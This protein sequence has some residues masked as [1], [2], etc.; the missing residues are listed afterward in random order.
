VRPFGGNALALHER[1]L[2]VLPCG[3]EDG[4]VPLV[5]GWQTGK[6]SA[7]TIAKWARQHCVPARLL[8]GPWPPPAI[9]AR[10]AGAQKGTAPGR[11]RQGN[12]NRRGRA[13]RRLVRPLAADRAARGKPQRSSEARSFNEQSLSPPLPDAEVAKTARSAWRYQSE[14]RNW[15][16][17]EG[18]V[19]WPVAQVLRCAP[20]KQGGDALILTTVLRAKH[21]TRKESFAAATRAMARDQVIPGWSEHRTRQGLQ[22]A[23]KLGL[24]TRIYKG[25]QGPG[26][27]SRY[28]L[29]KV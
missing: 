10:I 7:E 5:R 15:V 14:K 6:R 26:D 22:A 4:K 13:Q 9:P 16:G 25:G 29:S 24:I 11:R 3:K 23:L 20:H 21:A 28:R 1:G 2:A 19:T 18:H 27:P 8:G 17:S 12:D